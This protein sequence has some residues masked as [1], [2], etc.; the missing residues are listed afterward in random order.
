[1]VPVPPPSV[2]TPGRGVGKG[3]YADGVAERSGVGVS[4]TASVAVEAGVAVGEAGRPEGRGVVEAEI[5]VAARVGVT[6][7]KGEAATE[8]AEGRN[9][10][11]TRATVSA[12][13]PELTTEMPSRASPPKKSQLASMPGQRGRAAPTS[14][15]LL[16]CS[17][18]L[19]G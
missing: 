19:I 6:G 1:M 18:L 3:G 7:G 2:F 17:V 12:S 11:V 10:G 9:V 15:E 13:R 4:D 8:V 14:L 5:A 16:V